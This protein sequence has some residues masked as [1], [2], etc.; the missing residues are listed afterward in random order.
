MAAAPPSRKAFVIDLGTSTLRLAPVTPGKYQADAPAPE[1]L[2]M[3]ALTLVDREKGSVVAVGRQAANI[4]KASLPSGVEVVRPWREGL[5][6]AFDPAVAL[7]RHALHEAS[8]GERALRRLTRRPRALYSLPTTATDAAR[9]IMADVFSYAGLGESYPI[10]TTLAAAVGAEL[11]IKGNRPFVVCDIGAGIAEI[12]VI[13]SNTVRATRSWALGGDWL[14]QA[15]VRA[16]RR[17]RGNTITRAMAEEARREFGAL[18]ED[19]SYNGQPVSEAAVADLDPAQRRMIARRRNTGTGPLMAQVGAG[20]T[21]SGAAHNPHSRSGLPEFNPQ[22]VGAGLSE[23]ARPLIEAIV[24]FWEDL[25]SGLRQDCAA[26]GLTITGGSAI[27]PGLVPAIG[28]AI[29][30]PARLA[31]DPDGAT[32]RGLIELGNDPENWKKPWPWPPPW[33]IAF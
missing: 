13:A 18:D 27:L 14:D 1:A 25:E 17:R 10:P 33:E 19:Y 12:A 6:A 8:G 2:E 11:P 9:H 4:A 3:P 31:S 29:N 24:M 5:V 26:N 20:G 15:I 21:F 22:D 30:V 32:L 28:R 16:V 23:G 7:V